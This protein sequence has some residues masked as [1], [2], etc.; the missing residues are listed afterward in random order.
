M[1]RIRL[2]VRRNP[3]EPADD[4]RYAARVRRD[5]WAHAPV[6]LDP[7]GRVHGTQ[8][9]AD[10]N[11]Y[12]ELATELLPEV[13]R[14]LERL[15]HSDR[16]S[17]AIAEEPIGEA[18]QNCGSIAGPVLPT[19]CPTCGH[20]DIDPCPNCGSEVPRQ[21]YAGLS[22]DLFQCPICH[23]R[24]RLRINPEVWK[25]DGTLNEPVVVTEDAQ[26]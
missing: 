3:D 12:F 24:V 17:V 5:L 19:V 13:Q 8:R 9:D 11:V 16:V 25:A 26:A 18:C 2:T 6:E 7:D 15:G 10:R 22:G 1:P 14:V 20:R 23:Q 21:E 4:L